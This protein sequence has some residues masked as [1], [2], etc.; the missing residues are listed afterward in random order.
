MS[1][2]LSAPLQAAVYSALT[3]NVLLTGIV[4]DAIYDAMP[5]GEL[6]PIYVRLGAE[7]VRDTSDGTGAGAEHRFT[8][9]V[10]SD[11]PGFA[12]AKAA[13]GA[14][15]DIL[16]HADLNLSRGR[17]VSLRFERASARTVAAA[18]TRQIDLRFRARV[19]DTVAP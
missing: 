11:A 13:A 15:S 14:I 1:Y 12:D 8:V 16:H 18:Q 7:T 2:A 4:G 6:P 3:Q 9:S 17:L 10:V 5:P 19:D